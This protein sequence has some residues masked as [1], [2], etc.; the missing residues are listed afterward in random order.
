MEAETKRGPSR[1][2]KNVTEQPTTN[3]ARAIEDLSKE[4]LLNLYRNKE[5]QFTKIVQAYQEREQK[6]QQTLQQVTLEYNSRTQYFLDCVKHAYVSMQFAVNSA[7]TT[8]K[9]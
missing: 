6:L 5:E 8:E 1:P 4:E 2:P 9:E 7:K 3:E